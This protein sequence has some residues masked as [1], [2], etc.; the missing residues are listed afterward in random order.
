MSSLIN[1]IS[2]NTLYRL[3]SIEEK[4]FWSIVFIVFIIVSVIFAVSSKRPPYDINDF[5]ADK[6]KSVANIK[7]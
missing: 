6:N 2:S 3:L 7:P 5:M 4:R 1:V